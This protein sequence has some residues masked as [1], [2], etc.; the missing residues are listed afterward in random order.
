M[1][2]NVSPVQGAS[3]QKGGAKRQNPNRKTAPVGFLALLEEAGTHYGVARQDGF[4]PR[5]PP[6][7]Q[8]QNEE[9]MDSLQRRIE[10]VNRLLMSFMV[11]G[12]P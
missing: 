5:T 4:S 8:T 7:Q 1:T 3:G 10:Q 12:R 11:R 6:R 2:W 9:E